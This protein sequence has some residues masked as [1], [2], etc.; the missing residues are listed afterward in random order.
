MKSSS[1]SKGKENEERDE[2]REGPFLGI[3]A[4]GS[5]CSKRY[6]S[7][8]SVED[9]PSR[10]SVVKSRSES[11]GA[12][13]V[14][15]ADAISCRFC[16]CV[17]LCHFFARAG[18]QIC[19]MVETQVAPNYKWSGRD[20]KQLSPL[21]EA[22]SAGKFAGWQEKTN[23]WSAVLSN[24]LHAMP[25]PTPAFAAASQGIAWFKFIRFLKR[26]THFIHYIKADRER[27]RENSQAS[28]GL[29]KRPITFT[30]ISRI[31]IPNHRPEWRTL[32][33]HDATLGNRW[34]ERS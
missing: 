34:S 2:T 16:Q 7:R 3:V 1:H 19:Q 32:L 21:S 10:L 30:E 13:G 29:R 27:E 24:A 18:R 14:V 20:C 33:S 15:P 23:S 9:L 12:F 28:H 17:V 6:T 26:Q 22:W 11:W 8:M 31:K 4:V 5:E 25:P